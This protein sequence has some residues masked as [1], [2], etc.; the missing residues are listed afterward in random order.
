MDIKKL[1][2]ICL[3]KEIFWQDIQM[4]IMFL[5]TNLNNAFVRW[6]IIGFR[7]VINIRLINIKS[8]NKIS[9]I[10]LSL[11]IISYPRPTYYI[12]SSRFN[13]LIQ[14]YSSWKFSHFVID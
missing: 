11:I 3:I 13:P 12:K 10:F 7:T 8:S 4:Y 9:R 14:S 2:V 1:E 6:S 5:I